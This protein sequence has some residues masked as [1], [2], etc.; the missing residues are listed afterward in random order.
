MTGCRESTNEAIPNEVPQ[1]TVKNQPVPGLG[2][3]AA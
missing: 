3:F 1:E 2:F